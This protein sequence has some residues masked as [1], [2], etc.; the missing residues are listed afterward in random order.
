MSEGHNVLS[1]A[2]FMIFMKFNGWDCVL[3][4]MI[5]PYNYVIAIIFFLRCKFQWAYK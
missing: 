1:W 5:K 3:C 4:Q 2:K